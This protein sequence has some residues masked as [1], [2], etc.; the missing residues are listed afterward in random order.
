MLVFPIRTDRRLAHTPW[1]NALLIAI[2]VVVFALLLDK[3]PAVRAAVIEPYI[4]DPQNPRLHQFITYQFL[5]ASWM[6]LAGNMLFLWIFGNSI[7]DR[8]GKLGYLG[9]Y[10][11]GGVLA[12]LGHCAVETSA[13]LGYVP[14]QAAPVLGASGAIAA[15]TGAYLALFPLSDVTIFY[16]FVFFV[17]TFEV[18]SIYVIL[19]QIAENV[20]FQFAG[21]GGVAYLAHLAGYAFGFAAGMGLLWSRLLPREPYD[22]LALLEQRRRRAQFNALTR[23]GYQPWEGG[24]RVRTPAS[25]PGAGAEAASIPGR[26]GAAAARDLTP[27]QQALYDLRAQ[28]SGALGN[29]DLPRAAA[30]YTQL[31]ERDGGQVMGQQQ[32]LDLANQLMASG[33]YELAARAYE[34]FLNTY[35]HYPQ[36]EQIEL[37]LGLVYARYLHRRQR[38]IE[39][40]NAALPRLQDAGQKDLAR[41]TLSEVTG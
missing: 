36:R 11:A 12:G 33:Q 23:Q 30:L 31:L 41:Q 35:R 21:S 39:L 10:L 14:Q 26:S 7:E 34:L 13:A 25:A 17:G 40:L 38:A 6:H 15:V 4:L 16:W 22:L 9:F 3:Q 19:F 28:I 32:Q 5:H 20:V 24:G 18:A 27:A 2:N 1:V 37:I 29:H 8:L